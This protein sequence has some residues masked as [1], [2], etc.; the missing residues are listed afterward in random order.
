MKEL[1]EKNLTTIITNILYFILGVLFICTTEQLITTF[2]YILVC[3][4]AVIG[5]I[6][7]ISYIFSKEK[8]QINLII[9]VIF[10]W[11]A[12]LLYVYYGYNILS[13]LFSL[14]LFIMAV[15]LFQKIKEENI[16]KLVNIIFGL[17][18]IIT[19]VLLIFNA[20]STVF[21]YLKITGVYLIIVAVYPLIEYIKNY[22]KN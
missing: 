12:L 16:N 14:Y 10:I 1:Q 2:N 11:S 4:C 7:I 17:G 6:Q 8:K 5:I 20:K 21:T 22:K 13:I 18:A 3:V 9:G 15:T 19:G